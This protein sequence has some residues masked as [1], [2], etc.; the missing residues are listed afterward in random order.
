MLQNHCVC[1]KIRNVTL[2]SWPLCKLQ[3]SVCF[4]KHSRISQNKKTNSK[5][6]EVKIRQTDETFSSQKP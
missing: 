6:K 1:K 5:E 3:P 2:Q 4:S